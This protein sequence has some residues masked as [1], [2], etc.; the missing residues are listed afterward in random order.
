MAEAWYT[1]EVGAYDWQRPG[2][3]KATGHLTQMLWKS[4]TTVGCGDKS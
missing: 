1:A 3:A 4:T 2:L